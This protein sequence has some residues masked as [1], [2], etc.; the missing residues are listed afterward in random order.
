MNR[1]TRATIN[2]WNGLLSAARTEAA[3]RQELVATAIAIPVAYWLADSPWKW[4]LLLSVLLLVM[5]VE[6]L[7][8]AVEKLSDRV[9]AAHDPQ[10]GRVKDI[11]SASVGLAI[12]I[13]LMVWLVAAAQRFGLL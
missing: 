8:T 9:N 7:N 13:A 2:T 4:I 6:L 12:L 10:I 5:I 1:L 3:F 11:S